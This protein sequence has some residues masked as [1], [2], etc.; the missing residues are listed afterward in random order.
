ME[1]GSYYL[2]EI[3]TSNMESDVLQV[4]GTIT[5]NGI[6]YLSITGSGSL[7]EG[8]SI[9]II[10][11]YVTKGGFSSITPLYPAKGLVWDTSTLNN[12]GYLRIK[13]EGD[14]PP[15]TI[16]QE[17]DIFN[18]FPNPSNGKLTIALNCNTGKIYVQVRDIMGQLVYT[19]EY[20]NESAHSIDLQ[21]IPPG[22][23][24]ITVSDMNQSVTS[25]LMKQ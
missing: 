16:S 25:T 20:I 6:L 21:M 11:A 15:S 22:T 8:D 10:D 12:D 3:T 1:P 13:K 5:L 18:V 9:K 7:E 19:E 23:Y 17:K 14:T 4:M 2:C 24:L